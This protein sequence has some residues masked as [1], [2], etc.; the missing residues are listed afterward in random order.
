MKNVFQKQ[1]RRDFGEQEYR[2]FV[3]MC[4]AELKGQNPEKLSYERKPIYYS[5]YETLQQETPEKLKKRSERLMETMY[6]AFQIGRHFWGITLFYVVANVV[7][8]GLDLEYFV[9]CAGLVAM[10]ACFLY[11]LVEF[12]T[13]KYCFVDA[14][15]IMI[16]KAVLEKLSPSPLKIQD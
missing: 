10:G 9:T 1:L 16:Y 8:I 12:L 15:L 3:R 5:M 7:L 2:N 11:K 13:N 14:Y 6:K 4:H